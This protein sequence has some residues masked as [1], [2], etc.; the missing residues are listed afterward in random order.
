MVVFG[1][2]YPNPDGTCIRDYIHIYDLANAHVLAMEN[3]KVVDKSY[4]I[5]NLGSGCGFS[6]L[7]ILKGFEKVL[8]KPVKYEIGARRFGDTAKLIANAD[9]ANEKLGWKTTKTI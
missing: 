8:G 4:E 1:D 7:E 6:V 2:D 9:K 5:Y 3:L